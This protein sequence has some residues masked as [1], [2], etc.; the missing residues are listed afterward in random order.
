MRLHSTKHDLAES[1]RSQAIGLL[2]SGLVACIDL[3]T[4]TKQAH[5]NVRGG[6]FIALH[7][8]FDEISESVEDYADMIAERAVQ[9]GGAALGTARVVAAT[10]SLPEYPL[11]ISSCRDHVIA[12][13]SALAA[14]G[15]LTRQAIDQASELGD[16]VTCDVFTEVS[17]G[18]DK[19]LW[20]V[21]AHRK[22]PRRRRVRAEIDNGDIV[23]EHTENTSSPITRR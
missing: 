2:N 19:W 22:R 1:V 4:Q 12:L 20:M 16:A 23:I 13:S 7:K 18:A 9:L 3:Q 11:K 15:K 8:L 21:E 14:F 6:N 5:W 17:R 10:S